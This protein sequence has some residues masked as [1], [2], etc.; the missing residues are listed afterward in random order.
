MNVCY[1][2]VFFLLRKTDI[3]FDT[4]LLVT[5]SFGWQFA[6]LWMNSIT[7]S[8]T[9]IPGQHKALPSHNKILLSTAH[10]SSERPGRPSSLW[11]LSSVSPDQKLYAFG[12][13]LPFSVII[14]SCLFF[15][16]GPRDIECWVFMLACM[17]GC[18]HACMYSMIHSCI[19]LSVFP[20]YFLTSFFFFLFFFL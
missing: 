8:F 5:T 16:F 2:K 4:C 11:D 19:F 15:V 17:Y 14:I 3:K 20:S 9:S 12:F 1:L 7:D 6:Q 18:M 10:W 13:S